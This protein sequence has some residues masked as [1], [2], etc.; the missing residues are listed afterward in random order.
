MPVYL[1]VFYEQYYRNDN[2][3]L[4]ESFHNFF[5]S[6]NRIPFLVT[7]SRRVAYKLKAPQFAI[8][9]FTFTLTML[10]IECYAYD[11]T[12]FLSG[13]TI[14]QPSQFNHSQFSLPAIFSLTSINLLFANDFHAFSVSY[15]PHL[16]P[17]FLRYFFSLAF[18]FHS[19]P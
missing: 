18:P 8:E 1:Y 7:I 15:P 9:I 16:P 4:T 12:F 3:R 17:Q 5:I 6:A 2:S 19:F 10:E 11:N 14:Q 13:C